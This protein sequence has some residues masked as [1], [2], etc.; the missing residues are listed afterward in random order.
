MRKEKFAVFTMDVEA[1]GDTEC[2]FNSKEN[3][4]VDLL[5]GLDEYVK[6]L[7]KHNIKGT[8]FTVGELAPKIKDRLHKIIKNG[9]RLALHNF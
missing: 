9:H 7:D 5:D 8:F 4:N 6:I 1:F 2:V 3:L